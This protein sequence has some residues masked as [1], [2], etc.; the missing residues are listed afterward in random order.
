MVPD[1]DPET[2]N[3]PPGE[4]VATW[5]EVVARFGWNA[6]R[7]RILAGLLRAAV[8]LREAGC[9]FFLLDGSFVTA[10]EF[11]NDF[12][13]CCDYSGMNPSKID[14]RLMSGRTIMKAEFLGEVYPEQWLA[15]GTYTFREFFQS[16]RDDRPKGIVRL[17]LETIS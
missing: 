10:K 2:G 5:E 4:H 8:N 16:D 11:P 17:R 13:A 14:P 9:T 3:L 7:R 15:N 12:D 6:Q 1:F